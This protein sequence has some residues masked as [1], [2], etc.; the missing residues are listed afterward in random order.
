MSIRNFFLAKRNELNTLPDNGR[1]KQQ[2][3]VKDNFWP[4]TGRSKGVLDMWFRDLA[5]TKPLANLAKKAPSFNKKEEI[6]T[7][8]CD[9]QVSMKKAMW[10]LKLSAAYTT[11]VTEQKIKKRGQQP[12]PSIDWTATVIRV[13]K[14]LSQKLV[15]HYTLEKNPKVLNTQQAAITSGPSSSSSSSSNIKCNRC[16]IDKQLTPTK[17]T[18]D[19]SAMINK[20]KSS[21]DGK[22]TTKVKSLRE[23]VLNR[24]LMKDIR[25]REL[26]LTKRKASMLGPPPAKRA[27]HNLRVARMKASRI[28]RESALVQQ[29]QQQPGTSDGN[30]NSDLP[31]NADISGTA[32]TAKPA[33][34]DAS[35][36]DVKDRSG[37]KVMRKRLAMR[38]RHGLPSI[39]QIIAD[40]LAKRAKKRAKQRL[41]EKSAENANQPSNS[42]DGESNKNSATQPSTSP[43]TS[44]TNTVSPANRPNQSSSK[45]LLSGKPNSSQ[46]F[47]SQQH[48]NAE[49]PTTGT[50]NFSNFSSSGRETPN[51]SAT[52]ASS[53]SSSS[54]SSSSSS[55]HT[56]ITP[57]VPT[58]PGSVNPVEDF[59]TTLRHWKYC[60]RL[61]RAMCEESLLDRYE[62]LQWALELLDRMRN[63]SSDDG[64]LKL[65]MPFILQC[66]P[67]IVE[68]ERLSRRLAY[69]VCKKIGFMLHY[70][71]E[72]DAIVVNA[73]KPPPPQSTSTTC[74]EANITNRLETGLKL[75]QEPEIRAPLPTRGS[76]RYKKINKMDP[77]TPPP[78]SAPASPSTTLLDSPEDVLSTKSL[79][80]SNYL[81]A[82]SNTNQDRK[83]FGPRPYSSSS[84]SP[85]SKPLASQTPPTV[86]PP[87]ASPPS[88]S[89]NTASIMPMV[90]NAVQ[91]VSQTI[92]TKSQSLG[93]IK[94]RQRPS[95]QFMETMLRDFLLCEHHRPVI[96]E[97]SA[98][99]QAITLRCPGALVWC[100]LSG[101]ERDS[102]T[103]LAGSPLEYMPVLPSQLP[104][105]SYNRRQN[106]LIRKRLREVEQQIVE[107]SK[108]SEKRWVADKWLRKT[109]DGQINE[110]ILNTLSILDAHCFDRL[111]GNNNNLASLYTKLFQPIEKV[112]KQVSSK[113]KHNKQLPENKRCVF[114]YTLIFIFVAGDFCKWKSERNAH[115]VHGSNG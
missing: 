47:Q 40:I 107:R 81:P 97:L 73:K 91:P 3:N 75:K 67:Y 103:P 52:S 39:S 17:C 6:F 82:R 48:T 34:E 11:T 26:K 30:T 88:V 23:K 85:A 9:H 24:S 104:M 35:S 31:T 46:P 89:S 41:N 83:S 57:A 5:G 49:S 8:L 87:T 101:K 79:L 80:G 7:Y 113:F 43:S 70:V 28:K 38:K 4:V 93:V 86:S 16:S 94:H 36:V 98:M 56:F 84:T 71:T 76:T 66:L 69:L 111:D 114:I 100:G 90:S 10:F 20:D 18:K 62:F 51:V 61:C 63:K 25:F 92:S 19:K 96:M 108:H 95:N 65:F 29:Q 109:V 42:E 2:I 22:P 112:M 64:F 74:C 53:N 14:D 68:S 55:N 15:E 99:I 115:H 105:P 45:T 78:L 110:V 32:S 12:D 54:S 58:T 37:L 102:I 1:K 50:T 77:P 106:D 59:A 13:M 72:E 33:S 27:K 60:T 44:T 21:S